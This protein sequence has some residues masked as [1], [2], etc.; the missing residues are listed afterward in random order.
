MS[1]NLDFISEQDFYT[2][3]EKT[4]KNYGDKLKPYNLKKFNK[5]IIDPIKLIFDKN[6][7]GFAWEEIIKNEIFRQRDKSNNNDIGY[8][9]QSIFQYIKN[10][11]VPLNGWDVIFSKNDG[12]NIGNGDKVSRIFVEMKNKHNTMNASSSRTTYIKM[13]AQLLEDDDCACFLVEAIAKKSQDIPWAMTIEGS[14]KKHKRIRRVSMDKFYELVTGREDAFYQMCLKLLEVIEKV[15]LEN[16]SNSVPKDSV[17]EE[18]YT[19]VENEKEAFVIALYMLGFGSYNN[20]K[21]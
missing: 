14:Q 19:M 1:W 3:V 10:C 20:F 13:Q 8:F 11:E 5:N 2:H 21:K 12:I 16:A 18:L 6:I 15:V 7:Y 17:I 4:I 9:H